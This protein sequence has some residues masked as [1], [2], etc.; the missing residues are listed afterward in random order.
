[1]KGIMAGIMIA[2]GGIAYLQVGGIVGAALFAIGLLTILPLGYDLYTGRAGWLIKKK[3]EVLDLALIWLYNFIGIMTVNLLITFTP[4]AVAITPL[5]QQILATRISYGIWGNFALGI[6]CGILMQVAVTSYAKKDHWLYAMLPV[7]VFIL[8]GFPHCIADMFYYSLT[9]F[10]YDL[11][12]A[13]TLGNTLG[14]NLISY[15]DTKNKG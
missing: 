5:A 7:I 9:R 2:V 4:L 11:L 15:L 14:C 1:M 8:C 10:R 12:L 6:F 13:T 3:I